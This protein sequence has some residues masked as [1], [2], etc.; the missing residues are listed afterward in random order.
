MSRL[1]FMFFI[2]LVFGFLMM[3]CNHATDVVLV[4][5]NSMLDVGFR[6]VDPEDREVSHFPNESHY[7]IK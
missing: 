5:I 3:R 4:D 7:A 2:G 6:L 1:T